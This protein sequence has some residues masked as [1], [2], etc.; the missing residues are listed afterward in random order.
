MAGEGTFH[1]PT[2]GEVSGDGAEAH[3]CTVDPTMT[4][5]GVDL[6]EN[7]RLVTSFSQICM[8]FSQRVDGE[9]FHI[10]TTIPQIV[11]I[12]GLVKTSDPLHDI[13]IVNTLFLKGSV[14]MVGNIPKGT[15]IF[16]SPPA[17]LLRDCGPQNYANP[18]NLKNNPGFAPTADGHDVLQRADPIGLITFSWRYGIPC[19]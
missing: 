5:A 8:D 1:T 16:T 17:Y 3:Y 9:T 18:P 15:P 19:N 14:Q 6:S 11:Q 2:T 4:A 7:G 10:K 13:Q 12:L